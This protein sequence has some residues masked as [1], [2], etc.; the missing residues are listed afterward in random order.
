MTNTD[1]LGNAELEIGPDFLTTCQ[2]DAARFF[3]Y[4][5]GR[6][7]SDSMAV[8]G[9]LTNRG[10]TSRTF[11]L[12]ESNVYDRIATRYAGI[13]GSPAVYA[14]V[15]VLR[16]CTP[17]APGQRGKRADTYGSAVLWTE[18]DPKGE[19]GF[20]ERKL[21]EI[22]EFHIPPS[23]IVFSGRG[24]H[25]YWFLEEFTDDWQWVEQANKW[26]EMQLG[27]DHVS[28]AARV[29]RVP[30]TW[31]GKDNAR[32]F[33]RIVEEHPERIYARDRFPTQELELEEQ[34]V[35]GEPYET[36]E[37]PPDFED[38]VRAKSQK[39]WARMYSE[40]TALD[41]GAVAKHVGDKIAVDR[42]RN[43]FVIA[44]QLLRLKRSP[45]QV[46]AVLSHPTW[47]S[48]AKFREGYN[49]YY[50]RRTIA[51]AAEYI[52]EKE[53]Y[54]APLIARR[55]EERYV[56]LYHQL[57]WWVYSPE[58]GV[59]IP[60]RT[61]LALAIQGLSG[62]RWTKSLQDNV[63]HY[64]KERHAGMNFWRYRTSST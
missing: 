31:N 28:D 44:L 51:K 34:E 48:G 18:V 32:C 26:L 58:R 47:F 38:Q 60:G 36:E 30:G 16:Q 55:L 15:T 23:L 21:D 20:A 9:S 33:A 50:V 5:Y 62:I 40:A 10:M 2:A 17:L 22:R 13:E 45:G 4:L 19:E 1:Y 35:L 24:Y 57:T 11:P 12:D 49:E 63:F 8:I 29:L 14:R 39:L 41:A 54:K 61:E 3:S 25:L 52:D 56:I 7:P 64:L 46:F 53:L 43:D 27:G 42:S 59:F 37:L 6:C